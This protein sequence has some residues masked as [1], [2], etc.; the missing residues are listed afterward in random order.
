LEDTAKLRGV[1]SQVSLKKK[2][3][4]YGQYAFFVTV[5]KYGYSELCINKKVVRSESIGY[6]KDFYTP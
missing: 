3:K 2:K 5:R 1:V 6:P 4:G